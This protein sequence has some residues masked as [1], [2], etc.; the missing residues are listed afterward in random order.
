MVENILSV[1]KME[2]ED[3]L[4]VYKDVNI[5]SIIEQSVQIVK[6]QYPDHKFEIVYPKTIPT[7]YI[8]SDK[9]QQVIV[10]LTENAAKYSPSGTTVTTEI[11]IKGDYLAIDVKDEGIGIAEENYEKIF[12]KFSRLDTPLTRKTEGSGIGLYITKYIVE[13]M[14]GKI[15][16]QSSSSGS[17]FEVLMP[18]SSPETQMANKLKDK[19]NA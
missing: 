17:V 12:K 16:V 8:D 13:K 4:F 14:N 2:F 15:S 7:I 9:F 5:K 11:M 6:S 10:N 3:T 19:E 1:S 18:L